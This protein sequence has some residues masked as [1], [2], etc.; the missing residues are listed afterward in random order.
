M[1]ATGQ[2]GVITFA[3]ARAAGLTW[4]AI[5]NRI[6]SDRWQ[7]LSSTVLCTSTGQLTL[8]QRRWLGVLNGGDGAMLGGLTAAAVAG[9]QRWD[10][11]EIT[12]V[13]PYKA[14]VPP[15]VAGVRYVRS[16]R[17][18]ETMRSPAEGVPRM[19]IEPAVLLFGAA[20]RS[21][22]TAQ[23]VLA[24]VIQQQLTTP[25]DLVRWVRLLKPLKRSKLLH[26]AL[27]EMAGGAQSLAEIDIRRLCKRFGF[28]PPKGQVKRKDSEGRT[29]FTDCEWRLPSGQILILE[30]DGLFHLD[31]ES[32]EDDLARQR[33]L[34]EPGR[35]IIRCTARELRDDPDRI[36]RDLIKLGLPRAA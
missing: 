15:Q 29:R 19:L 11:D 12:V 22:R 1:T 5:A 7:K 36:A 20:D 8:E 28:P 13:V 31:V 10:R 3:Q 32:W 23:G 25:D 14:E 30:V 24:A 4:S 26:V 17:A 21:E 27:S 33:A 18:I 6:R 2:A 16:R 35:I 34:S 9:L